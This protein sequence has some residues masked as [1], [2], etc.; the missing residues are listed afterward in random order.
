MPKSR[1][2]VAI[3][4]ASVIL[5]EIGLIFT[6][7]LPPSYWSAA[8]QEAVN[9]FNRGVPTPVAI[10]R[11]EQILAQLNAKVSDWQRLSTRLGLEVARIQ[12]QISDCEKARD[13]DAAFAATP[14]DR[15]AAPRWD[16]RISN[17]QVA[18]RIAQEA[19]DE[20]E[21]RLSALAAQSERLTIQAEGLRLRSRV[22]ATAGEAYGPDSDTSIV[23]EAKDIASRVDR[24]MTEEEAVRR[25][26]V[27]GDFEP[28]ANTSP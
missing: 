14:G 2:P 26:Q 19:Y 27:R 25:H 12:Q 22:A 24:G 4:I 3:A 28:F 21:G 20:S 17:L 8:C 13:R 15:V 1:I 6:V 9:A 16:E 18:L 10:R 5:A 7:G 23:C 11:L